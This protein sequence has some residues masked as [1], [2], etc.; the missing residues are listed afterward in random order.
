M[1]RKVRELR[2]DLRKAGYALERT[3]GSHSTWEH[4]DVPESV[5]VSGGDGD[6]A[7]PYQERQVREAIKKAKDA[8]RKKRQQP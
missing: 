3:R 7:K 8:K 6:D 4:P 2:G 5:T 1:P